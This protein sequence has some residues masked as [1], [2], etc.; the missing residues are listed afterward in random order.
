M[1]THL[2][3]SRSRIAMATTTLEGQMCAVKGRSRSGRPRRMRL[4]CAE[5]DAVYSCVIV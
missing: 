5:V 1:E 4:S 2:D 3:S